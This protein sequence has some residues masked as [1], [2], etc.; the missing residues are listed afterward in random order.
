MS[1]LGA[2][3]DLYS[4]DIS[5]AKEFCD[6]LY[7]DRF[8]GYF[9]D[10][11]DLGERLKASYTPISDAELEGMLTVLP[12][13]LIDVSEKLNAIKLEAE[14]I[15]LKMKDHKRRRTVE[16]SEGDMYSNNGVKM[17]ETSKREWIAKGVD[18]EMADHELLLSAY[19]SVI[20]RV[21][22]EISMSRELIMGVK[23]IWDGRRATEVVNPVGEVVP[24]GDELPDYPG[25]INMNKSMKTYI[26]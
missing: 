3:A 14:T 10:L 19:T 7:N 24:P 4:A 8:K 6:E 22:R 11:K 25:P 21:E 9:E 26:K 16:L 23:K 12:L 20:D 1:K 13:Q 15:R 18:A 5:D 2:L 17:S